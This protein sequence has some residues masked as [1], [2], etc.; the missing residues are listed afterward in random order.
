MPV[1]VFFCYARED[2]ALLIRLKS[3]LKPL[4]RQGLIELW[5]DREIGAGAEWEKEISQ[6]LNTAQIILLL[7]SPDFMSSEYCYGTE[8]KQALERQ[9]RE[10]AQVIPVIGRAVYWQGLLGQLQ[11]LPKNALPITDPDWY[12][13]DRALYNITEGLRKVID[14][15]LCTQEKPDGKEFISPHAQI[16]QHAVDNPPETENLIYIAEN[17]SAYNHEY[18]DGLVANFSLRNNHLQDVLI[19]SIELQMADFREG[20]TKEFHKFLSDSKI[21]APLTSA[22]ISVHGIHVAI[23]TKQHACKVY[24]GPYEAKVGDR[25]MPFKAKDRKS[26]RKMLQIIERQRELSD[27]NEL[28]GFELLPRSLRFAL[29]SGET[30]SFYIELHGE[31]AGMYYVQF[32]MRYHLAN[33]KRTVL[34]DKVYTFASRGLPVIDWQVIMTYKKRYTKHSDA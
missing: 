1:K 13:Q 18:E 24:W 3:H 29:A 7:V 23:S 15:I 5:Y 17:E 12:D 27:Q 34:S 2:E 9:K 11:A 14:Q 16:L 31:D 26:Y 25:G 30:E 33:Q 4:E 28:N 32:L 21:D 20:D 19:Y 22:P 6:H 8:L 10:E